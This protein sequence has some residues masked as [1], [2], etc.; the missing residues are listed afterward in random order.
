VF[1]NKYNGSAWGSPT[2]INDGLALLDA[3]GNNGA[4]TVGAPWFY[5]PAQGRFD[6]PYISGAPPADGADMS[7][8]QFI[9]V[10]SKKQYFMGGRYTASFFDPA[11]LRW[12]ET[13]ATGPYPLSLDNQGYY[14]P[15]RDR[16]YLG[17]GP[18]VPVGAV[19]GDNFFIYDVKKSAWSR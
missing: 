3:Q 17:G 2:V 15:K 14:D 19:P 4:G 16:I 18:Y 12:N 13:G 11:T 7:T 10:N 9:Y 5:D 6:R 8:N 1:Y